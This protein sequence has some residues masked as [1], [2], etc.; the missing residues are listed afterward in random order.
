M[1]NLVAGAI[2]GLLVGVLEGEGG[3]GAILPR[4]GAEVVVEAGAGGHGL[5][6]EVGGERAILRTKCC[7]IRTR[8]VATPGA[9]YALSDVPHGHQVS[10]SSMHQTWPSRSGYTLSTPFKSPHAHWLN[11]TAEYSAFPGMRLSDTLGSTPCILIQSPVRLSH[12][13]AQKRRCGSQPLPRL[14]STRCTRAALVPRICSI[15]PP[16]GGEPFTHR[17][18]E[19]SE[20][21]FVLR[22]CEESRWPEKNEE[23]YPTPFFLSRGALGMAER[24]EAVGKG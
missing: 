5:G 16:I 22:A 23:L 18:H 15:S 14:N 12:M 3:G 11:I 1:Y 10:T 20:E 21:H 7:I 13:Q 9:T 2:E 6:V 24:R 19:L 8:R 4:L 17:T